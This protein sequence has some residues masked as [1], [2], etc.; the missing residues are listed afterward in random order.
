MKMGA[1][2]TVTVAR[3]WAKTAIGAA[4]RSWGA[5]AQMAPQSGKKLFSHAGVVI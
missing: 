4:G 2:G 3:I 1:A 5:A